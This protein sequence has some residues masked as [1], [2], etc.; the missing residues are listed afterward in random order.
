MVDVFHSKPSILNQ[1]TLE[2]DQAWVKP[3]LAT[4]LVTWFVL[5]VVVLNIVKKTTVRSCDETNPMSFFFAFLWLICI[6]FPSAILALLHC[7]HPSGR[8]G[9]YHR[10]GYIAMDMG[11]VALGASHIT[12]MVKHHLYLIH[13]RTGSKFIELRLHIPLYPLS[14]PIESQIYMVVDLNSLTMA[15]IS[16]AVS[17]MAH[18]YFMNHHQRSCTTSYLGCFGSTIT[19][20]IYIPCSSCIFH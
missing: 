14:Y 3:D 19:M 7:S 2:V 17:F 5:S 9:R 8:M 15:D 12:W 16:G 1:S 13:R 11:T 18:Q 10:H 20:T 6:G 4:I